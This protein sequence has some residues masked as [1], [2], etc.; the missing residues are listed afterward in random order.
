VKPTTTHFYV[1]LDDFVQNVAQVVPENLQ[2]SP[3]VFFVQL[4]VQ[5][6]EVI[7]DVHHESVNTVTVL[8]EELSPFDQE[9]LHSRHHLQR[10]NVNTIF[11]PRRLFLVTPFSQQSP[12]KI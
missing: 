3:E 1:G 2:N 11:T 10:I 8:V 9:A 4:I 6:G 7:V 12:T 5:S